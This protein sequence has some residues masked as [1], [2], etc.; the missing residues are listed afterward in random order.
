M[1]TLANKSFVFEMSCKL[2][3]PFTAVVAGP[4][5]CG[6]SAWV[7]R[8]IDNA[9]K[10]IDLPPARIYYC[11]GEFQSMFNNYPQV[12]FH[13]GL[14]ELSDEVFDG[15]EPTLLVVDDL[16]AETNQ[17]VANIFTKISHHRNISVLHIT[18]L[19]PQKQICK[20]D[21]SKR[22]LPCFLQKPEG[23]DSDCNAYE[24]NVSKLIQVCARG[25]YRCHEH[26]VRLS[27]GRSETVSRRTVSSQNKPFPG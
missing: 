11:Y 20:N 12:H 2:Q 13:E 27:G 22:T 1:H 17:L 5:G 6:K 15:R 7:L 19:V 9:R 14:P 21:K 3:H 26:A 23:R 16:M 25:L 18:K 24:T 4:T 10:M 8:L